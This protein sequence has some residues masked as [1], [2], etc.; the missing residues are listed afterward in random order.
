MAIKDEIKKA[1]VELRKN[2]ERKFE[3]S[4]DLI[5]NLQKYEL[6]KN[7]LN[8]FVAMP[9]PIGKKKIA[10]FIDSKN[11]LI[12][13]I[14]KSAFLKYKDAKEVKKLAD[15]YEFFIAD[16]K[17]MPAVAST[18]GR[19]L[20]PTGKMPSPQMGILMNPD[21]KSLKDLIEKIN[22]S[23]KIRNK[24]PSVKVKIATEKMNDEDIIENYLA[25]YNA[26]LKGLAKGIEN[27]KNLEIKFTMTKPIKIQVR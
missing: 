6:K 22:R 12:D 25:I 16:A 11:D 7:Q 4:V 18:F 5:I 14:P 21:E 26:V 24:E 10:G 1:L 3:Q 17:L 13:T 20:G 8:L 2:K 15:K 23:I 19:V 9:H 27:V